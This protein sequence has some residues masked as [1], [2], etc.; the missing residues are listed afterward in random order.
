MKR[1]IASLLFGTA[2]ALAATAALPARADIVTR[3]DMRDMIENGIGTSSNIL[4]LKLLAELHK[5]DPAK[6]TFISPYSISSTLGIALNGAQGNTAKEIHD[7]MQLKYHDLEDSNFGHEGLHRRL[8]SDNLKIANSLWMKKGV[9]FKDTFITD[10]VKT[11]GAKAESLKFDDPA[12]LELINNWVKDNTGGK[13]DKLL[14]RI[15]PDNI[16]FMANAV[17]FK[18][19]WKTK[20]DKADSYEGD[21]GS[22][23]GNRANFMKREGE[24]KFIRKEGFTAASLPYADDKTS[25]L[26]IVPNADSSLDELLK[27]LT[28]E[29]WARWSGEFEPK[30]NVR[31]VL[32]RLKLEYDAE[33]SEPL[34]ALGIKEA[35]AAKADFKGMT[36]GQCFI[37]GFK[38]KTL[39]EVNEE[40]TEAAAVTSV[41]MAAGSAAPKRFYNL[42][43]DKPFFYAICDD[44]TGAILFMGTMN[45][46]KS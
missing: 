4:G 31:V 39:V 40:G 22:V 41:R 3:E 42:V 34:K 36:D 13:I 10:V 43:A 37:S 23:K 44:T 1:L 32:P 15:S 35:F 24:I 30:H 5:K 16:L 6:N 18:A 28:P 33:L 19:D 46:P 45:N 14:D 20:F 21:F 2:A 26:V 27:T 8:S 17:Y 38:H 12:S 29:N 25:M 9:D 7:V 11:F